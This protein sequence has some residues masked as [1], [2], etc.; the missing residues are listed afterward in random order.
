MDRYTKFILTMIA[1]ALFGINY[2]LFSGDI[3][4][5]A[6]ASHGGEVHKIAICTEDG[7]QCTRV[8]NSGRLITSY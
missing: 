6:K 4:S 3:I 8:N 1:V 2:H 7:S 5:S